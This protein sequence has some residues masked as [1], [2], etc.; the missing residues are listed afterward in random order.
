MKYMDVPD[1]AFSQSQ[2]CLLSGESY[3]VKDSVI[4]SFLE[5]GN[6]NNKK[7]LCIGYENHEEEY[8]KR[9]CETCGI[10]ANIYRVD[11]SVLNSYDLWNDWYFL[12]DFYYS[13]IAIAGEVKVYLR[14]LFQLLEYM[15]IN[16]SFL[17][18]CLNMDSVEGAMSIL[19]KLRMEHR[20][21]ESQFDKLKITYLESM[22]G[23]SY[24]EEI[25]SLS[26]EVSLNKVSIKAQRIL[27]WGMVRKTIG[28]MDKTIPI[29]INYTEGDDLNIIY[30]ILV[31][32]KNQRILL[33]S[34]DVFKHSAQ[35]DFISCFEL[36]V[37]SRTSYLPSAQRVEELFGVTKR[38]KTVY[39]ETYDCRLGNGKLIDRIFGT[40]K[41]A[42]YA[43]SYEYEPMY[44]KEE[45]CALE[46]KTA[47]FRYRG[48][49]GYAQC[50]NL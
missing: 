2:K 33:I 10:E 30:E 40:N 14:F 8:I 32:I 46:E 45:I 4:K 36:S 23:A 34:N 35:K 28:L 26:E 5:S 15:P 22:A 6:S 20:I 27:Y 50:L 37:F 38:A 43:T 17:D 9:I 47:L 25:I 19:A 24:L 13:D 44:K 42:T 31:E 16:T 7:A 12:V 39:S 49:G 21:T 11:K 1:N 48:E 41:N 3:I 29:I 18:L